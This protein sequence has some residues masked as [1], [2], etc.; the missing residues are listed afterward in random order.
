M[1]DGYGETMTIFAKALKPQLS[2]LGKRR[3]LSVSFS[4]QSLFAK[5][6]YE[7][8][9]KRAFMKQLNHSSDPH[10]SSINHPSR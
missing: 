9:R 4:G 5:K 2:T 8:Q 3:I 7:N 10:N 6:T 1:S